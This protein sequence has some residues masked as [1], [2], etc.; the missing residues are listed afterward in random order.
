MVFNVGSTVSN[1]DSVGTRIRTDKAVFGRPGAAG[2]DKIIFSDPETATSSVGRLSWR[3]IS[4]YRE[5]KL[6][7]ASS[8]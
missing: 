8:W 3:Q 5:L 1:S 6:K 2:D 7:D 4:N